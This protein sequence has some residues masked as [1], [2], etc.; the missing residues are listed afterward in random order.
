M[1]SSP[2]GFSEGVKPGNKQ[3]LP[4]S[5][6]QLA[7]RFLAGSNVVVFSCRGEKMYICFPDEKSKILSEEGLAGL[8][9]T[10][11]LAREPSPR[12]VY[13][14]LT[15]GTAVPSRRTQ[16]SCSTT[17]WGTALA[18]RSAAFKVGS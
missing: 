3:L 11:S 15:L 8:L 4:E 2:S 13:V 9:L 16:N 18:G 10:V 1:N 5:R 12:I 7:A 14:Y 6:N 17:V